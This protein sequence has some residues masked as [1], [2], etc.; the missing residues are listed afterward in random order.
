M[1][2]AIQPLDFQLGKN[3]RPLFVN[4]GHL[5]ISVLID[6]VLYGLQDKIQTFLFNVQN[7]LWMFPVLHLFPFPRPHHSF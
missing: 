2:T 3:N 6:N 5:T 4:V 1:P 7:L